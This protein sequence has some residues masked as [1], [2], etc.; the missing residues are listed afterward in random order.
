VKFDPDRPVMSGDPVPVAQGIETDT[1]T[2]AAH[3]AVADNG[4]LVYLS[5][6]TTTND[7]RIFWAGASG[8]PLRPARG[9]ARVS[10]E[11]W[12]MAF[13]ICARARL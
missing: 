1:T 2:G 4:T 11:L 6:G 9:S 12:W 7:R 13:T 8:T 10:R 5:G 3:F